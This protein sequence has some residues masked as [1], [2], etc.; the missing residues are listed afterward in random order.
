MNKWRSYNALKRGAGETALSFD[1][2]EACI[3]DD[4][5]FKDELD[6]KILAESINDFLALLKPEQRNVFVC[7]YWYFESV[8]E[9]AKHFN[10]SQSKVKMILKRTRDNLKDYLI[11][12]SYYE[13]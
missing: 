3:P 8:E 10:Y 6:A 1:E 13:G 12:E 9:I 7:R 2:L 11:K 5:S 4:K